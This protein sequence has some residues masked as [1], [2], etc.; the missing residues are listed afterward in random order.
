MAQFSESRKSLDFLY[1]IKILLKRCLLSEQALATY[2]FG[3]LYNR[4]EVLLSFT[5]KIYALTKPLHQ[6]KVLIESPTEVSFTKWMSGIIQC[7]SML[8]FVKQLYTQVS[9]RN[10]S[11]EFATNYLEVATNAIVPCWVS[12]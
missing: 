7:I 2:N 5:I 10:A 12:W 9:I 3:S 8:V 1:G 4:R 6:D 11:L